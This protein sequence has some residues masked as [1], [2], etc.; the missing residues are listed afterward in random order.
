EVVDLLQKEEIKSIIGNYD[1]KVMRVNKKKDKW[2]KGIPPEKWVAFN[3]TYDKLSESSLEYVS[4]LGK[5]MRFELEGKRILIVHGSPDSDEESLTYDTPEDRLKELASIADA[6][7]IILGHSHSPFK[8][9]IGKVW[10]INPGSVGRPGDGNPKASYAIMILKQPSLFR[11][12]HY[13]VE[14][15]VEKSALAIRESGLPEL[16]AQ[17]ILQGH[18]FETIQK[19]AKPNDDDRLKA[20]F[21]LAKS[22]GYEEEHSNQVAKLSL[23]LFDELQPLHQLGQRERFLLHNSAILHDIGWIE[24]QNKHHKTALKIILG[25]TTLLLNERERLIVGSIA[26]YHRA[27]L[28]K[29]KH[30]HFSSLEPSDRK[31]VEVLASI[32]RIADGLDR[33]HQSMVNSVSCE[34]TMDRITIRCDVMRPSEADRQA[35]LDKG[36]LIQKVFK[37]K[38]SIEWQM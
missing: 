29:M 21:Q 17:M 9:K 34:I 13:R 30:P 3:W 28:P 6:D 20:S 1:L 36:Q 33:T 2:K 12:D 14:Y 7:I 11:I 5:E 23:S 27:A 37:K 18:S 16:F 8:R 26:R 31:I 19:E 32:L 25:D 35:A 10:F 15:D 4:S 24:G 38:L 22:C